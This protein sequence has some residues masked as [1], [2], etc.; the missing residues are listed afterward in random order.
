[1]RYLSAG[2]LADNGLPITI[3]LLSSGSAGA[4]WKDF[5]L[6]KWS[7]MAA[8]VVALTAGMALDRIVRQASLVTAASAANPAAN[9][10]P[11]GSNANPG[12]TLADGQRLD[13]VTLGP[14]IEQYIL[15][16][17]EI[18]ARAAAKLQEK[19]EALAKADTKTVL[20]SL[21]QDLLHD[22]AAPVLGNPQGDV[23]VVEFFD[24]KC[25]YCKR[26]ADDLNKL[27]VDDP[28][29]RVVFKEFPIL[30]PDSQIAALGGLAANR[31]GKYSAFH[32]AAMEHRGSFSEDV[33]MDLAKTAG[34]D[35]AQFQADMKDPAFLDE[36]KKN[37]ALAERLSIDGT[38]A[39][40]IG[41]EKVP[42][43]I[44]YDDMKKLVD[45]ARQSGS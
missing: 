41:Q 39:F 5:A 37:Q 44:G 8:I 1:V 2:D 10:Q 13:A 27:I 32:N 12:I 14:V 38:P 33:V 6:R 9:S 11:I 15:D 45:E 42:G 28:K 40:I 25:P 23:T 30:G 21:K 29:V 35:I 26:V 19:Q 34:L 18:L 20:A 22:P 43:A 31:Q 3:S 16:H 24:Y 36:I 17:P 7:V 4:Y